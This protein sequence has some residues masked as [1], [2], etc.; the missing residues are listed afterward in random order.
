M[1]QFLKKKV[2][3]EYVQ[4]KIGEQMKQ[5]ADDEEDRENIDAGNRNGVRF[6][7]FLIFSARHLLYQHSVMMVFKKFY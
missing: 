6:N 1:G 2:F 4:N 7:L 3:N 5:R